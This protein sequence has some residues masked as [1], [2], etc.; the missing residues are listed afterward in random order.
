M[1]NIREGIVDIRGFVE[2]IAQK[3]KLHNIYF[4]IGVDQTNIG[5]VMGSKILEGF[6]SY[7]V[8]LHLGG[9]VESLNYMDFSNIPYVEKA[10]VQKLGI[11]MLPTGNGEE[12]SKVVVPLVRG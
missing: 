9:S 11:A 1:N 6:L 4:F 7:R 3:G 10:K 2:N 5:K 8:G 12:C